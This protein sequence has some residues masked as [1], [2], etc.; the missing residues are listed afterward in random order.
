MRHVHYTLHCADAFS[1]TL[2]ICSNISSNFPKVLSNL[3]EF[4]QIFRKNRQISKNFDKFLKEL[5]NFQFFF[6]TCVKIQKY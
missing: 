2:A 5:L 3:K 1:Q 4:G 6:K